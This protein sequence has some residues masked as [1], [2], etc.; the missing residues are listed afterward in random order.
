MQAVYQEFGPRAGDGRGA[1]QARRQHVLCGRR[2]RQLR[3]QQPPVATFWSAR[4]RVRRHR[5]LQ[6]RRCASSHRR[7]PPRSCVPARL[8]ARVYHS[9]FDIVIYADSSPRSAGLGGIGCGMSKRDTF[10]Q[11]GHSN[12]CNDNAA[13]RA[14]G[15]H[16]ASACGGRRSASTPRA[17]R[18]W[19]LRTWRFSTRPPACHVPGWPRA[20]DSCSML[21]RRLFSARWSVPCTVH[22]RCQA[23]MQLV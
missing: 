8:D 12:H 14:V 17:H 10:W 15:C 5:R 3:V 22:A 2:H 20:L 18:A 7:G 23:K 21:R 6:Q 16:S 4:Q 13:Q 1:W 9:V 11:L 19:S